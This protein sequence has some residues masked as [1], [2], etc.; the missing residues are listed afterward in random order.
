MILKRHPCW[1][2]AAGAIALIMMGCPLAE[3]QNTDDSAQADA[4]PFGENS[5][6]GLAM[7]HTFVLHADGSFSKLTPWKQDYSEDSH[8]WGPAGS[9]LIAF[10]KGT[11]GE[12]NV[13]FDRLAIA[14]LETG[15]IQDITPD[16]FDHFYEI[17]WSPQ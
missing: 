6:S 16:G 12:T 8:T 5:V 10:V 14:T 11:P 4:D 7:W 2:V 17:A 1:F 3:D 15:D 9:G 13:H